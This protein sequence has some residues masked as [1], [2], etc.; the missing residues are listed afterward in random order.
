MD[1]H[2]R[3]GVGGPAVEGRG[4][5]W[6]SS[7]S[8]MGACAWCMTQGRRWEGG[9]AL[10]QQQHDFCFSQTMLSQTALHTHCAW[11][12]DAS[13]SGWGCEGVVAW[14]ANLD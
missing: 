9:R 1:V 6:D 14:D 2:W 4:C 7:R 13:D 12:V 11:Q 5:L 10:R 8:H 3:E